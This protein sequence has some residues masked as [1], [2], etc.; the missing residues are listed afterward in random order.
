M[1]WQLERSLDIG[2]YVKVYLG[3][4]QPYYGQVIYY[5]PVQAQVQNLGPLP[6]ASTASY[7]AVGAQATLTGMQ[8]GSGEIGQWRVEPVDWFAFTLSIMSGNPR[9]QV[10]SGQTAASPLSPKWLAEVYT[11]GYEYVP[12]VT[13]LNYNF[14]QMPLARVKFYGYRYVTEPLSRLP[15]GTR[16]KVII[17]GAFAPA[18]SISALAAELGGGA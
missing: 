9:W 2:D 3:T 14:Y 10:R 6:A 7:P 13:P 18:T 11:F 1:G 5:E 8:L 17:V 4:A 12:L 16:A 15:E